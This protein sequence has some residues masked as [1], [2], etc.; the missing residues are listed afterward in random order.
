MIIS[1][2]ERRSEIGL[3]RALGATPYSP[4]HTTGGAATKNSTRWTAFRTKCSPPRRSERDGV[5]VPLLDPGRIDIATLYQLADI[6][7]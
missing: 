3:R 2:L 7:R 4:N 6:G 5:A 1:V